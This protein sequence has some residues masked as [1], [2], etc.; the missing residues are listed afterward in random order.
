M[1]EIVFSDPISDFAKFIPPKE[2]VHQL[3][4]NFLLLV[5]SVLK[6]SVCISRFVDFELLLELKFEQKDGTSLVKLLLSRRKS[7]LRLERLS[8]P[9]I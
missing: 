3:T 7:G 9:V 6:M 5:L 8:V 2:L 4:V 1:I